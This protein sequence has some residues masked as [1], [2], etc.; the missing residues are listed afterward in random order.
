VKQR[1]LGGKEGIAILGPGRVGQAMGRLLRRA[2]IPVLLVAAR[3]PAAARRAV[4]FIGGGRPVGLD[5]GSL[6]EASVLLLATSDAAL[7]PLARALAARRTGWK[8]KV[9]L[10]TS[11]SVPSEILAPLRRRGAAV[12]SIHPYQTIPSP[13]AGLRN[14]LGGFWGVEGDAA[15]R[16]VALQWVSLLRGTAFPVRASQKTLYHASAFLVCPTLLTL[17]DHSARLLHCAGVPERVVR[18]MLSRFVAETVNSFREL[19]ARQALTGPVA[20][21]DWAVIRRH[22]RALRRQAPHI[23]PVYRALLRDMARLAGLR[24]PRDLARR[25]G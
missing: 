1:R 3:R 10:H 6:Q 2:G 19:G 16:R 18:P 20:R 22:L 4:K 14:L 21:G 9:V 23:L 17:M 12:G 8:G 25:K 5:S 7:A 11:G 13:A 15:A 24:L